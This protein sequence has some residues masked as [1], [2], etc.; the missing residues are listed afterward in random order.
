MTDCSKCKYGYSNNCDVTRNTQSCYDCDNFDE[1]NLECRCVNSPIYED[2]PYFVEY[3][4][5]DDV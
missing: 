5:E 4:V 1:E 2:C 3:E